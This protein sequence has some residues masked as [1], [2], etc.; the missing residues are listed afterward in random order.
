MVV[1]FNTPFTLETV[2]S[3]DKDFGEDDFKTFVESR[4]GTTTDDNVKQWRNSWN[5]NRLLC[6]F[7]VMVRVLPCYLK[8]RI[9]LREASEHSCAIPR[10]SAVYA[11]RKRCL[12]ALV[13]AT[14]EEC[15]FGHSRY[16][17]V[18]KSPK[19][20]EFLSMSGEIEGGLFLQL[21][22]KRA[23]SS[24]A[25]AA[26]SGTLSHLWFT[27]TVLGRP[28]CLESAVW[29]L[30]VRE[31]TRLG[32]G[33]SSPEIRHQAVNWGPEVFEK[34]PSYSHGSMAG[35][36]LEV[37][38]VDNT[39]SG[40]FPCEGFTRFKYQ[41]RCRSYTSVDACAGQVL[42]VVP[43]FDAILDTTETLSL[44]SLDTSLVAA[45]YGEDVARRIGPVSRDGAFI[46]MMREK[47]RKAV[48][49]FEG[50][51][52][53]GRRTTRRQ[54]SVK[55][56][57]D[58][59]GIRGKVAKGRLL[60]PR[61]EGNVA[62][63]TTMIQT[64]CREVWGTILG[65]LIEK[66]PYL[67]AEDEDSSLC[68]NFLGSEVY[69]SGFSKA[70]VANVSFLLVLTFSFQRSQVMRDSRVE[71]FVPSRSGC[72]YM[73]SLLRP[74]KTSGTDC[75]GVAPV[76]E[77]ELSTSQSMMVHFVKVFG[78]RRSADN[79]LVNEKG[80]CM[81]QENICNRFKRIG[82]EYLQ[83]PNLSPHAMRTFFATHAVN[84][85]LVGSDN[86]TVFAS[87][88]QVSAKTL[89]S[90]YAASSTQSAAHVLGK[91]VL[92]EVMDAGCV[93]KKKKQDFSVAT[94]PKGKV[95]SRARVIFRS[96]I[97]SSVGEYV[98]ATE[99]FKALVEKRRI[100]SL[101]QGESWFEFKNSFFLDED[102]RFFLRFVGKL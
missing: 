88:L 66:L 101:N 91:R 59:G 99:C 102:L 60:D 21:D 92:G 32:L 48:I 68:S 55:Q 44:D 67:S 53:S 56:S 81:T 96:E 15:F 63:V 27:T 6:G 35:L 65:T 18:S 90:S 74:I 57:L 72:G 71:E 36:L 78:Q 43:C 8:K 84:C 49:V 20:L 58:P 93:S 34:L 23:G 37:M 80:N 52:R 28:C 42:A 41:P 22:L 33:V 79:L 51:H 14:A 73:L 46:S 82:K 38:T 29:P 61:V 89:S 94:R 95:L 76:R 13:D 47:I 64:I 11:R 9:R 87:Y 26:C 19:L 10:D 31:V 25:Y 16:L 75:N 85:G 54:V 24:S 69:T 83:I 97:L 40:V 62:K 7:I 50:E 17:P 5:L 86:M 70:D 45:E 4:G 39:Y 98:S 12:E 100:G 30:R 77:F 1:K 2:F 3:V